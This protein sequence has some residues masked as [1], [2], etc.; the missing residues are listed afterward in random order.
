MKKMLKVA[1][2]IAGGIIGT[3]FTAGLVAFAKERIDEKKNPP[4]RKIGTYEHYIKRPL[5]C[6]LAT[7]ATIVFSPVLLGTAFLVKK[8]LGSPVIYKQ[9]R[10]GLNEKSFE[11]LKFRTMTDEKDKDGNLLPDE[12]RLTSFGIKLRSTSLDEL[13][14]LINII[15]GEMAI[16]GPRALPVRYIPFYTEEEHH[17]HDVRPGLS[18]LAEVNGRNYVKWEDK[19][20][21]DNEYASHITFLGDL[22]L[23]LK[24]V[25]V[26]VKHENIETGSSIEKDGVIY[27]PLD[28]ERS[29]EGN[30]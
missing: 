26:V 16:I 4:K 8:K 21:M 15:K 24:T 20:R 12:D 25:G 17:R 19:F 7:G 10:A 2:C 3:S 5:D 11:I 28:V 27:R 23:I 30:V 22:K 1:G 29:G 13:P 9:E 6:T 14:S 18:G